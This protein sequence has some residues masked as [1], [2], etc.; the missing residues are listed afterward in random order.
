MEEAQ[1]LPLRIINPSELAILRNSL[2]IITTQL[3]PSAHP[4]N[5]MNVQAPLQFP[6]APLMYT[7]LSPATSDRPSLPSPPP[8][9]QSQSRMLPILFQDDYKDNDAPARK[10]CPRSPSPAHIQGRVSSRS[11][12]SAPPPTRQRGRAMRFS[13]VSAT[14]FILT[15]PFFFAFASCGSPTYLGRPMWLMYIQ[16]TKDSSSTQNG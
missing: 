4:P 15:L 7:P 8:D 13:P 16:F 5:G 9:G 3:S 1:N 12:S 14:S 11:S 6:L 2:F 10:P